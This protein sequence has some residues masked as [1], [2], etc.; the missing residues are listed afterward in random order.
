MSSDLKK[1][2][3]NYPEDIENIIHYYY[4]QLKYKD[5]MIHLKYQVI[6]NN[7]KLLT[8]YNKRSNELILELN[9][10]NT[11]V[12]NQTTRAVNREEIIHFETIEKEL[13]ELIKKVDFLINDTNILA[14]RK[15]THL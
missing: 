15:E 6:L 4:H 12:T 1:E 2:I 11:T 14:E 3:T 9:Q 8:K 13:V 7:M 5:I 10:I